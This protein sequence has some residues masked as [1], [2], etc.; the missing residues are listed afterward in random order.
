MSEATA[1]VRDPRQRGEQICAALKSRGLKPVWLEVTDDQIVIGFEFISL[2]PTWTKAF[3]FDSVHA[4][5][6]AFVGLINEWKNKIRK[7]IVTNNPSAVVRNSISAHG[8]LCVLDAME[9]TPRGH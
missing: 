9:D 3:H 4:T 8:L 7:D 5:P 6:D 1:I 2:H